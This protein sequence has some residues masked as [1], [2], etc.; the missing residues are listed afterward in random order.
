MERA[1]FAESCGEIRRRPSSPRRD[2]VPARA[3]GLARTLT[4]AAAA[5]ATVLAFGEARAEAKKIEVT[6]VV[7]DE[8]GDQA[9]SPAATAEKP[10]PLPESAREGLVFRGARGL[11]G[12]SLLVDGKPLA[13]GSPIPKRARR[14]AAL[15]TRPGRVEFD[16]GAASVTVRVLEIRALDAG[17]QRI[18]FASSHASVERTPP[19]SESPVAAADAEPSPDALRYV[20]MGA[21]E[22]LPTALTLVSKDASGR[23]LDTLSPVPLGWVP[24]PDQRASELVCRA[25]PLIR[26]VTD[27]VDKD[28]PLV[29]KRSIR[30]EVGGAIEISSGENDRKLHAIR[31]GGPRSTPAG[32][33]ERL[34]GRLRVNIVRQSAGGAPPFGGDDAG[35]IELASRQ[36]AW[37]GALWGQCG[38]SFGAKEATKVRIVDPPTSHLVAVGC[39]LGLPASGGEVRLR[40]EGRD[41]HAKLDPGMTPRSAARLIAHAIEHAGFLARLSEN[42]R[43]GPGAFPT[44]DVLVRKSNGQLATVEPQRSGRVSTDA[45][46]NVCIGEVDLTD[47]L[48]HFTDVDAAAGT[49]EER[50]LVKAIDDRNDGTVEVFFIPAFA[51]GGRIGESFI[52]ADRSSIRNVVLEDRAGVRADRASFALAHELGHVFLDMP[53]HPDDFGVDTPTL[54][55][56][57][58]AADLSAFGPRRLSLEEC[59]RAL[60]QSGPKAETPLLEEW[61]LR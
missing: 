42:I 53:G 25:T 10:L 49:V 14:I 18:S 34:R 21:S 39:D 59:A 35:A 47:G 19:K 61:P 54:L 52:F 15:G 6:V 45:T 31:I 44:V 33:I 57:S 29:A 24:C 28:H 17:G 46:M 38:I 32:A 37:A 3:A 2:D 16:L 27:D 60:R 55:M 5:L 43:I 56:D 30:A 50:T 13:V 48:D 22:D 26:A 51:R 23:I 36:V 8:A 4:K 1:R 11:G 40:V 9:R 58:D 20:L 7:E 41:V 12:A